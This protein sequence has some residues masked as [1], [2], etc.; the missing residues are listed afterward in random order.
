MISYA[1]S[2]LK[3]ANPVGVNN[4]P[5]LRDALVL[6]AIVMHG[7]DALNFP[8]NA[9]RGVIECRLAQANTDH[10]QLRDQSGLGRGNLTGNGQ[11]TCSDD[12][13]RM[14]WVFV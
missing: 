11:N 2:A 9:C 12:P 10:Q 4:A 5:K 14:H 7:H 3:V 6:D 1:R 8:S 13:M